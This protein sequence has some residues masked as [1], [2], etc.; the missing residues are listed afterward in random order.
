MKKTIA[1]LILV[2]AAA[3]PASAY[4]LTC[5]RAASLILEGTDQQQGIAAGHSTG[6]IDVYAGLICLVGGRTCSCLSNMFVNRVSD[7]SAA[8]AA[9][10]NACLRTN[11]DEPAFGPALR[12]AKRVCP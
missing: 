6:V 3:S 5:S 12:A 10:I 8:M 4:Y 1:A 2:L 11:P 7:Y 9:E